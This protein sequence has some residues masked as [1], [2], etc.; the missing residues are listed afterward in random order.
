GR[1]RPPRRPVRPA[2]HGDAGQD[3]G[4]ARPGRPQPRLTVRVPKPSRPVGATRGAPTGRLRASRPCREVPPV[5]S[6]PA[7]HPSRTSGRTR[8]RISAVERPVDVRFVAPVS[9]GADRCPA[10]GLCPSYLLSLG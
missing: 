10:P 5:A 1:G 3:P 9:P 8:K 7:G 4:A 6:P 2:G